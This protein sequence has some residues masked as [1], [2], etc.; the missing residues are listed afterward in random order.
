M[1]VHRRSTTIGTAL[2][3]LALLTACAGGGTPA[4]TNAGTTSAATL[5][6]APVGSS[7]APTSTGGV[8]P[9]SQTAFSTWP[10]TVDGYAVGDAPGGEGAT[11]TRADGNGARIVTAST[12]TEPQAF[13]NVVAL[14]GDP[15]EPVADS[16]CGTFNGNIT[17]AIRFSD[18]VVSF[19]P[20]REAADATSFVTAFVDAVATGA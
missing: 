11:Y 5:P 10:G 20:F 9:A 6:G 2:A 14:Q 16:S 7:A 8:A 17:C 15:F 4:G 1:A 18:T 13:E 12:H 19:T 3:A